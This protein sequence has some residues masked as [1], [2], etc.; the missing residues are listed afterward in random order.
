M[1]MWTDS[2]Y[3]V[4]PYLKGDMH[5]L[6]LYYT[7]DYWLKLGCSLVFACSIV[8]S[9]LERERKE[10]D[11]GNSSRG[12]GHNR[13]GHGRRKNQQGANVSK[14]DLNTS[15]DWL[16]GYGRKEESEIETD[17]SDEN[18]LWI[19]DSFIKRM[20]IVDQYWLG[21]SWKRNHKKVPQVKIE[22]IH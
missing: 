9:D 2:L 8:V 19:L 11:Y 22:S 17:E 18:I 4:C 10:G 12:T 21:S 5:K 6:R 16:R 20:M 15:G 14:R 13:S 3:S 7:W 1:Q